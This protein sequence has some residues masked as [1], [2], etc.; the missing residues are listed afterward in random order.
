[1]EYDPGGGWQIY[2]GKYSGHRAKIR[3]GP[4][5]V[6]VDRKSAEAARRCRA[7]NHA[8]FR[9]NRREKQVKLEVKERSN[10]VN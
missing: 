10:C 3:A 7:Q 5:Q 1:M 2:G 9:G 8:H 4:E 6:V